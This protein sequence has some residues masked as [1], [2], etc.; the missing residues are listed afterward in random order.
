VCP[1]NTARSVRLDLTAANKSSC[2]CI[3]G[4]LS[5]AGFES[6]FGDSMQGR[7]R[8]IVSPGSLAGFFLASAG[9]E[10]VSREKSAGLPSG[11]EVLVL[12][13]AGVSKM[14]VGPTSPAIA[15]L[16][17]L[18]CVDLQCPPARCSLASG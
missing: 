5:C 14:F 1:L 18:A 10:Q 7:P 13:M 9:G 11:A 2:Q 15:A 17:A 16:A 12:R 4:A 8:A 3:Q 6:V